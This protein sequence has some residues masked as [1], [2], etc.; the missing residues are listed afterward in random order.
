MVD[1]KIKIVKLTMC[2]F[3]LIYKINLEKPETAVNNRKSITERTQNK[4]KKVA[5]FILV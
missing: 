5:C 3:S 2:L 4:K 1:N